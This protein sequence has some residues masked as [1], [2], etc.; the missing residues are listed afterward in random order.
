[1]SAC[2]QRI[3][4]LLAAAKAWRWI[5]WPV[6]ALGLIGAIV[7]F[8][9]LRHSVLA[10]QP[11]EWVRV[12]LLFFLGLLLSPYA[13]QGAVRAA[14]GTFIS[15]A[16]AQRQMALLILG[17]YVPGQILGVGARIA[18]ARELTFKEGAA[19]TLIE[20][21]LCVA[22]PSIVA[23]ATYVIVTVGGISVTS[24]LLI[25]SLFLVALA[26]LAT[27]LVKNATLWVRGVS[28]AS[29]AL[30]GQWILY[31]AAVALLGVYSIDALDFDSALT[32]AVAYAGAYVIG[33]L[34]V[35]VPS[36]IG[37]R[38]AAFAFAASRAGVSAADAL[39]VAISARLAIT[40][41]EGLFSVSVVRLFPFRRRQ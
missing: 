9:E 17:K 37:V 14:T 35:F 28:V 3:L 5:I 32:L 16:G 40:A 36:G 23:G 24:A 1:M 4:E 34:A 8:E 29:T 38:E 25:V 39:A 12:S 30:L 19:S 22:V 20:Q 2:S 41:A 26:L 33:M 7:A 15:Y 27:S 13:W 18:M 6:G 11:M 31:G 21:S 10:L